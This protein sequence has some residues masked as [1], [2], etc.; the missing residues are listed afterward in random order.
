M[1]AL[2]FVLASRKKIKND[3]QSSEGFAI[4]HRNH[5]DGVF[6]AKYLNEAHPWLIRPT[7][8]LVIIAGWKAT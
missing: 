5:T 4:A 2:F 1:S 8:G 3:W 6:C 7:G